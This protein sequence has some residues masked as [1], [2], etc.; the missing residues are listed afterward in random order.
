MK[1]QD[2]RKFEKFLAIQPTRL[3]FVLPA[4][5]LD[6]SA[7]TGASVIVAEYA[8]NNNYWFSFK[9]PI[10]A[11]GENFVA[12]IRYVSGSAVIRAKLFDHDDAVLYYPLYAGEKI[13]LNAVLEIWSV[14]TANAPTLAAD[15]TLY[16]SV[17]EF[18][19]DCPSCCSQ[20]DVSQVLATIAFVNVP[21]GYCNPF[22]L[23]LSV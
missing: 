6:A 2:F 10:D 22:C 12:A 23:P 4:F 1:I 17:L 9:L 15:E 21:Y 11:F 3:K 8:I 7:W 14:N 5:T 18:P 13:G 16:S 20:P 19:D